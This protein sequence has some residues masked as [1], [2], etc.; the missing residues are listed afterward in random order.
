MDSNFSKRLWVLQ[1]NS[2]SKHCVQFIYS[3]QLQPGLKRKQDHL[4]Q[5]MKMQQALLLQPAL[6]WKL[7]SDL[8]P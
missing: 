1:A 3:V 4:H 7:A 8:Q 5:V 6:K 2:F